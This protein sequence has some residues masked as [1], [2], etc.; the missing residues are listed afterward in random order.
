MEAAYYYESKSKADVEKLLEEE[1]FK[2]LGPLDREARLL[3]SKRT[4]GFYFYVKAAAAD[5]F[6]EAVKLIAE[7]G[8][9]FEKLSGDEETMVF[10]AIHKEEDEAAEGMGAIFG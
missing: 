2:R 9:P 5:K 6:A 10:E 1:F 7:S 4:S 8:I 3:G